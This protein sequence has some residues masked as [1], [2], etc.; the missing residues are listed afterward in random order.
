MKIIRSLLFTE[1]EMPSYPIA[2]RAGRSL[3][4]A[5]PL[6]SPFSGGPPG[7]G[8]ALTIGALAWAFGNLGNLLQGWNPLP[9]QG[10]IGTFTQDPASY[11]WTNTLFC[12]AGGVSK[13]PAPLNCNDPQF[14]G[15]ASWE[16]A[17]PNPMTASTLNL[18]QP[19]AQRRV[20][21]PA[22]Y[23]ATPHSKWAK[24]APV[25]RAFSMTAQARPV[26]AVPARL[27]ILWARVIEIF[28][29]RQRGYH[30]EST[31]AYYR[32]RNR[33][34]VEIVTRTDFHVEPGRVIARQPR[35]E[36]AVARAVAAAPM[37]E[38]KTSTRT[39]GGRAFLAMYAAMNALGDFYGIARSLWR[40]I[41]RHWRSR[42]R[43]LGSMAADI[44]RYA[45][46]LRQAPRDEREAYLMQAGLNMAIWKFSD[47]WAGKVQS[48]IFNAQAAVYGAQAARTW[49]TLDSAIRQSANNLQRA[50]SRTQG[51]QR[52]G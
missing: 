25:G 33:T 1:C 29:M 51:S 14:V 40:A 44:Y 36:Y 30:A 37:R 7:A 39:A 45:G 20:G 41:P 2:Y 15:Q 13:V 8:P 43:D 23:N 32:G 48:E 11:G 3:Q 18:W 34:G 42:R 22:G 52:G 35:T 21:L 16:A 24:N 38:L 50:S 49:S 17:G 31:R 19:Y 46:W 12:K 28:G 27:P 6:D 9:G 10:G 5:R 26:T 47:Y 4:R